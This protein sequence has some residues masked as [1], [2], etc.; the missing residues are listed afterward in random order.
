MDPARY[1]RTFLVVVGLGATLLVGFNAG[2]EAIISRHPQ[3]S[4]LEML[5]AFA[6]VMKPAWLARSPASLVVIGTSRVRD[7]FDP[8]LIQQQTGL[9]VFN[10]GVSGAT[11]YEAF[12]Y[13]QDAMS[14]PNVD[15]IVVGASAFAAG[16]PSQPVGAGFDE[17]DLARTADGAPTPRRDMELMETRYLS[18]GAVGLHVQALALLAELGNDTPARRPDLFESYARMDTDDLAKGQ[19]HH[20]G[21][22]VRLTSWRR[23]Y[24]ERT[25]DQ[26]CGG[27]VRAY[28]FFPPDHFSITAEWASNDEAGLIAFRDA[29]AESVDRHNRTCGARISLFDFQGL[30]RVTAEVLRPG[31]TSRYY[32]EAVHYRPTVGMM[33]LQRM[34]ADRPIP[35]APEFGREVVSPGQARAPIDLLAADLARWRTSAAAP[36]SSP[37]LR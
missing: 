32:R 21:R 11:A 9:T 33:I 28:L 18:G 26:F 25:L 30:S 7:G 37:L 2:A 8:E 5:S 24:L 27:R 14:R 35:A 34:L 19:S 36:V 6:R 15:T 20:L 23:S 31:Q 29:I 13:T 3:A 1:V 10:Y 17:E 22:A 12:R 16:S 4:S